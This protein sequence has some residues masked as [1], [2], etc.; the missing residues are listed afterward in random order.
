MIKQQFIDVV[1][2]DQLEAPAYFSHVAF[3]NCREHPALEEIHTKSYQPLTVDQVI[4]EKSAGVQILDVR[5][6]TEFGRGHLGGEIGIFN[7]IFAQAGTYP[8]G[9]RRSIFSLMS[10][11]F[12]RQV[13]HV[14]R[15]RLRTV[16]DSSNTF[17]ADGSTT[18]MRL[19]SPCSSSSKLVPLGR[20]RRINPFT[21]ST[22]PFSQL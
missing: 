18:S 2:T 12:K 14:L 10:P 4:H 21:C 17:V 13:H 8:R 19:I 22:L 20:N 6:P 5:S 7:A 11:T 16:C 9:N 1:T 3:L 15:E